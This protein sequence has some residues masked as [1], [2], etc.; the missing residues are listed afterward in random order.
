MST[1]LTGRRRYRT[2]KPFL[3]KPRVV[4]QV[5]EEV[6]HVYTSGSPYVFDESHTRLEWRDARPEDITLHETD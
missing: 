5:E 2:L 4:L 3:R 6:T 1:K